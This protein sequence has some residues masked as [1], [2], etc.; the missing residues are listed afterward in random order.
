MIRRH[1]LLSATFALFMSL[2]VFGT[3]AHG[4]DRPDDFGKPL[5]AYA[6]A[7]HGPTEPLADRLRGP[8][9]GLPNVVITGYW[10]PTNEM[11]RQFSNNLTQN[12][13]GWVGEDWEG[14]GYNIYAFFPEFPGGVLQKGEGDFE[15]DYQDTS[16]DWWI[17]VPA[18]NPIGIVTFSRAS[19]NLD[20][21]MEGGN[22]TYMSGQWTSDY[23]IP[24]KPTPELPIMIQEPPMTERYSTQPMQKI[25]DA[26]EAGVPAL[27]P[28]I[29]ALDTGRFLS[30][31]IGYHGCWYQT[32]HADPQDP[33][34]T[35]CG[36]HIHV[37]Y[38]MSIAQATQATEITMRVVTEH[39]TNS[40]FD[41]GDLN[42]DGLV[43]GEDIGPMIE[44]V[45][46]LP[47]YESNYPACSEGR[48]DF[49]LDDQ[50]NDLDIDG[51]ASALVSQP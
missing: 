47:A 2:T 4:Q 46:N 35:I 39:L 10:P 51:F 6:K 36:G 26:V 23:L 15:V 1:V 41:L 44:A 21:E 37:G 31:F 7:I 30:N 14:R 3:V 13:G 33:A 8:V 20:W 49:T 12:P 11:V 17:I 42:C 38:N 19:A 40:R 32:M 9:N 48:G 24:V 34:W 43:D 16:S 25:A 29:T 27:N 18:L 45:L 28:I 22:R 50:T 5:P